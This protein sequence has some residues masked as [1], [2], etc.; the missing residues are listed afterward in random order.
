MS[1]VSWLT[2]WNPAT[3]AMCPSSSAARMRLGV[4]SMMRARPCAESVITPAWLPVNE[5][6]SWPS[7]AIAIAST[8]I[9]IRSPAV[10]NMSSSRAGGS[11]ETFSASSIRSSVVSPMAETTTQ[12]S[13]PALRVSTI[14][15]A[16]RLTLSASATDEPPYFCTIR[17]TDLRSITVEIRTQ[18]RRHSNRP[19]N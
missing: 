17:L 9:E 2:P 18:G 14:R 12:T 5:R 1:L 3:M 13:C 8:A 16:T 11:G 6:A 10:S 4:T 19:T 7:P 15:R